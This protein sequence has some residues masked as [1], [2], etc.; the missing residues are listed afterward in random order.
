M[1]DGTVLADSDKD[2]KA[3]DNHRMRQ[4]VVQAGKQTMGMGTRYSRTLVK[5]MHYLALSIDNNGLQA[6]IRVVLPIALVDQRLTCLR[7][8]V[9]LAA[10]VTTITAIISGYWFARSFTQP[11]RQMT[12]MSKILSAGDFRQQLEIDR[13]DEIGDLA[14]ALNELAR[15]AA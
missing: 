5:P 10:C 12:G 6:Y 4:E 15:M 13:Q 1:P 3:M 11:P 14:K 8:V 9:I 2:P 7:N